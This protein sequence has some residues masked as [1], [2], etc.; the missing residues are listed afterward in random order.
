M[1]FVDGA[2]CFVVFDFIVYLAVVAEA[3]VDVIQIVYRT[4]SIGDVCVVVAETIDGALVVVD[5]VEV[6]VRAV[7]VDGRQLLEGL[8]RLSEKIKI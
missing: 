4:V 3:I 2:Q 5:I 8:L 6:V 7:V 1:I